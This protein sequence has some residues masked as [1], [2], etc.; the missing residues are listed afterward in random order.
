MQAQDASNRQEGILQRMAAG[1]STAADQ[2]VHQYR[3]L[4]WALARRMS[5][6]RNETEDAV[7]EIFL[8]LW[9][10]AGRFDPDRAPESAFVTTIA[11][12]RLID[13]QRRSSRA[14]A[15]EPFSEAVPHGADPRDET[16]RRLTFL[17]LMEGLRELPRDQQ[18]VI[19]LAVLHDRTHGE[20]ARAT[21]LPLG[22]VKSHMRRGLRKL[23]RLVRLPN[24]RGRK[25]WAS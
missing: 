13:R 25:E 16:T 8:D 12:R 15:L 22:T 14:P 20:I 23:Q 9:R 24:K 5:F 1:D 7:Q 19:T 21:G 10:S 6:D 11:R 2:C 17:R 3:N 4:V 18:K